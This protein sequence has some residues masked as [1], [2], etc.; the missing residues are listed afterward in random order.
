MGWTSYLFPKIHNS[1]VLQVGETAT[2][3]ELDIPASGIGFIDSVAGNYFLGIE[4]DW[5]IDGA[6]VEPNKITRQ[7]GL[8]TTPTIYSPPLL[9]KSNIQFICYNGATEAVEVEILCKGF[10]YVRSD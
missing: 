9:V 6:R 2:V 4:W 10:I 8:I 3:Y 7:L 1:Q 5:L